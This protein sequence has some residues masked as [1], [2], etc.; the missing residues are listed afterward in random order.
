MTMDAEQA[1]HAER[2]FAELPADQK[3]RFKP[4]IAGL[5]TSKLASSRIKQTLK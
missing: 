2:S 5:D 1:V 3:A 4:Q